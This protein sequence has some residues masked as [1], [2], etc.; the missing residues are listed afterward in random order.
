MDLIFANSHRRVKQKVAVLRRLSICQTGPARWCVIN[1]VRF[2]PDIIETGK[3][4]CTFAGCITAL[5]VVKF[6]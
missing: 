3:Q 1:R 4:E 5:F 2:V 6:A